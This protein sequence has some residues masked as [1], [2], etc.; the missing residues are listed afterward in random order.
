MPKRI[1]FCLMSLSHHMY[2]CVCMGVGVCVCERE[3][4]RDRERQR[5]QGFSRNNTKRIVKQESRTL[6]QILRDIL[7]AQ[8]WVYIDRSVWFDTYKTLLK[9]L[10]EQKP[11][12][13]SEPSRQILRDI[14]WA[15]V[16]VHVALGNIKWIFETYI[17]LLL[18]QLKF[19]KC[20]V[21]S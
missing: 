21:W 8:C 15:Q 10:D 2:V 12:L 6:F 17:I 14:L 13:I 20:T 3:T 1:C 18:I 16:W 4:E 9:R 11:I 5:E 7:C 19:S